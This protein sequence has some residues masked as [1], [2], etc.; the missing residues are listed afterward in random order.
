VRLL[1][2]QARPQLI[3]LQETKLAEISFSIVVEFLGILSA[4]ISFFCLL[5]KLEV[6]F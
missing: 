5:R 6:G 4:I 2:Q 3:Y 1:I